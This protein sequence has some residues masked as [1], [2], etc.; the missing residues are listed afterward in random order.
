MTGKINI[1]AAFTFALGGLAACSS[2]SVITTTDGQQI[3]TADAPEVNEDN[4]FVEYEKDGKDTRLNPA[5]VR[6]IEEV[7]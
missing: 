3:T 4:G 7:K 5:E 6:A 2:P 1:L